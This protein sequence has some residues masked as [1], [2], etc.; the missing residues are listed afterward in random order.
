[1]KETR[2][3]FALN[4]ALAEEMERDEKVF[5]IG[6]DVQ[7]GA[8]GVSRGLVQKFGTDRIMDT[9]ISETAIAGSAVGSAMAGYRPVADMQFGDFM[10]IAADEILLKAAKWRFLH[11][12]KMSLPL[13]FMACIGGYRKLG[14]EHSQSPESMIMHTPGLKLAVPSTPYDAKGLMKTAIRDNNPVVFFYHKAL[15]G[16][17]GE[18]P[19][20]EYTIPFGVADVKREGSDVTVVATSLMVTYALEVAKQLEDKISV[21]VVDPRTLEPLDMD[22]IVDSVKKTGRAVVVDEDTLRCGVTAEIGMQI[23]EQAFDYLDAPVQRVA[24]ANLPIAS[25]FMEEYVLPQPRQIK[26]A[27]EAV[28]G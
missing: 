3:I 2:Y 27:I 7:A 25:G 10:F 22:T 17:P 18:I 15:L 23:M 6:E 13:V 4:E 28:M 11:G 12:K 5:I 14:A 20:E 19:E 1:M 26:A 21:E 9:P 16:A 24:A 8:F